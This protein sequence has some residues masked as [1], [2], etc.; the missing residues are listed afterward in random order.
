MEKI[1]TIASTEKELVVKIVPN[2]NNNVYY[3]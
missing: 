2:V 3:I 1:D